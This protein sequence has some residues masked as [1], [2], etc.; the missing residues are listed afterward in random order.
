MFVVLLKLKTL[1]CFST[2]LCFRRRA[3]RCLWK[4]L[5]TNMLPSGS[6]VVMEGNKCTYC[7]SLCLFHHS[8][9]SKGVNGGKWQLCVPVWRAEALW[10]TCLITWA[11]NLRKNKKIIGMLFDQYIRLIWLVP[12]NSCMWHQRDGAAEEETIYL[13]SILNRW[14]KNV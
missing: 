14:L 11:V 5:S 3:D 7:T 4:L 2:S 10:V 13:N 1:S 8:I 6:N 9:H 12:I